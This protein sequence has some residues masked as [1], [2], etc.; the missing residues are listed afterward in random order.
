GKSQRNRMGKSNSPKPQRIPI[1]KPSPL[2]LR[3]VRMRKWG[4]WVSEV[5]MPNSRGKLWL[6]T[7]DTAEQAAR[8]YDFALF[9]IRGPRASFNFPIS[10]PEM[11]SSSSLSQQEIQAAAA[12]FALR[13]FP[14]TPVVNMAAG[15]SKMLLSVS[16]E[17]SS[18][19]EMEFWESVFSGNE[20]DSNVVELMAHEHLPFPSPVQQHGGIILHQLEWWE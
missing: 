4:K 20:S 19:I 9:C 3:G 8:A 12:T 1:P 17:S 6:G 16:E 7:Y 13:K 15:E 2:K 5:R 11:P 10:P 18:D 14:V